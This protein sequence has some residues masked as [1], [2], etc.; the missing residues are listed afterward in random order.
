LIVDDN[1]DAADSLAVLLRIAG[2]EV[3]TAHDCPKAMKTALAVQPDVVLVDIGLPGMDGYDV[4][5]SL[6]GEPGL[7]N[8][9]VIAL[10]GY[11]QKEYINY[12]AARLAST[13][14]S[15]NPLIFRRSRRF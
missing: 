11:G 13:T 14:I 7:D 2:H 8:A 3:H 5:R 9:L 4:A 15:S 10:T 12:A 1:R 6:R